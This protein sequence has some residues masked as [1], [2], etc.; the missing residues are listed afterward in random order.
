MDVLEG[1]TERE[2]NSTLPT[3]RPPERQGYHTLYQRGHITGREAVEID[4]SH[5]QKPAGEPHLGLFS[6]LGRLPSRKGHNVEADTADCRI[7]QEFVHRELAISHR[8]YKRVVLQDGEHDAPIS[9]R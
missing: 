5:V 7:E 2:I 9:D 8:L 4:C 3:Q 1:D 6:F